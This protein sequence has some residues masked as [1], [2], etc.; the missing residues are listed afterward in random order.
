VE[1]GKK[2]D[3][4]GDPFRCNRNPK[5]VVGAWDET[6]RRRRARRPASSGVSQTHI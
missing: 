6:L 2:L 1:D 5:P 3:R 4:S